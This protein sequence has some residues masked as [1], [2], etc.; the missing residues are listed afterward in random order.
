V[1]VDA[2]GGERG[3]EEAQLDLGDPFWLPLAA[4]ALWACAAPRARRKPI[5][6]R[7][8]LDFVSVLVAWREDR[9]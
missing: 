2:M 1:I 3:D 7:R 6:R 5:V 8:S 9:V 4:A